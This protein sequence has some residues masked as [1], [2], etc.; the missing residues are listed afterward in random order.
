MTLSSIR[1]SLVWAPDWLWG[2]ALLLI[3][4]IGALIAHRLIGLEVEGWERRQAAGHRCQGGG[5]GV[6]RAGQRALRGRR[7]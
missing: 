1:D 3:A 4:A 2:V 7:L 5:D 6:A